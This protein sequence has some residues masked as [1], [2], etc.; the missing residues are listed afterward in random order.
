MSGICPSNARLNLW[1]P[2]TVIYHVNRIEDKKHM[3]IS[4]DAEKIFEENLAHFYDKTVSKLRIE[5]DFYTW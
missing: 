1:K 3:T 2:I 4:M 5:K